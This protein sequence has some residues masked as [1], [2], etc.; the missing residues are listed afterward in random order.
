MWA[1]PQDMAMYWW[2]ALGS[3]FWGI[4][5]AGIIHLVGRSLTDRT[6]RRSQSAPHAAVTTATPH[7]Q[8]D[9]SAEEEIE[10]IRDKFSR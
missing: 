6:A 4:V 2:M 10:R 9:G 7:N 1:W 3:I 8:E 5:V